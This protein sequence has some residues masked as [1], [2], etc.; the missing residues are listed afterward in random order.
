MRWGLWAKGSVILD[1]RQLGEASSPRQPLSDF[2]RRESTQTRDGYPRD[3]IT[4]SV[5]EV[6][7]PTGS[8]RHKS[9]RRIG[10]ELSESP[11][12]WSWNP[13]GWRPQNRMVSVSSKS[14][15]KEV[16]DWSSLLTSARVYKARFHLYPIPRASTATLQKRMSP[17]FSNKKLGLTLLREMAQNYTI[18]AGGIRARLGAGFR[19]MLP[20]GCPTFRDGA[21]HVWSRQQP[22]VSPCHTAGA[23]GKL[24]KA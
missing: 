7:T 5:L 1:G 21:L 9:G 4:A 22:A 10:T 16:E 12:S 18:S 17:P 23:S 24:G 11:V 8:S 13:T 6:G 20:V 3:P 2:L 14:W 15:A 19:T